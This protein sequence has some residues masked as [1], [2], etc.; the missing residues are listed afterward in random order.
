MIRLILKTKTTAVL[1]LHFLVLR[2]PFGDMKVNAGIHKFEF[3]EQNNESPYVPLP[4]PD[5]AECNRLLASKR[6]NFR[7]IMFL[8]PK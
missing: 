4:L 1:P 5:S 7:I 8:A 2:G 3:N 6:I